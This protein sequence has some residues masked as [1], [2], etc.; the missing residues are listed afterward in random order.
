M[1]LCVRTACGRQQVNIK[2][3]TLLPKKKEKEKKK[4]KTGLEKNRKLRLH[5][6]IIT[7]L[8]AT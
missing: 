1:I 2:A 7:I 5:L 4:L 6:Y 3:R 8:L